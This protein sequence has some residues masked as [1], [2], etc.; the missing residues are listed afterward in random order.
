[1][2][3]LVENMSYFFDR[4]SEKP[5][6]I[7]GRGGGEK[8]SR[9]FGLPLLARLLSIRISERGRLRYNS[10]DF[11]SEFRS[12]PHLSGHCEKSFLRSDKR[13]D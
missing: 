12:G 8:L 10:D 7:F 13:P 3:G 11:F 4:R 1:M 9:E 6:E 5:I 2:I